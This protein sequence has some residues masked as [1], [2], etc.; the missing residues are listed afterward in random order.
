MRKEFVKIAIWGFGAMGSGM[1]RLILSKQGFEITGVCDRN[2]AY[3]GKSMYT[4]LG[5]DR[6][7]HPDVVVKADI[8]EVVP[9]RSCDLALLCTDSFTA[10]AFPKIKWLLERGVDVI[11]TAEEMAYPIAR[12]PE[13]SREMDRIAKENGVTVLGTGI[14]PG[15]MMDLLVVMLTGVMADVAS[16]RVSRINS[17]SPFGETVMEEQG[18]GL[19]VA[20]FEEKHRNGTIAGHVGFRESSRMMADA[21]GWKL[22]R[23]EQQMAPIVTKTDR[24]SSYGFAAAGDVAGVDMTAQGYV[25]GRCAIDMRHPQ[26][27]EPKLGNVETGDYIDIHGHPNVAMA[28]TPEID[29]GIGT[30][31]ICVNMIPHVINARPG[32]KT[33]LDL[34]VP[35]AIMGDVRVRIEAG[36]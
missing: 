21:L 28:I 15:V 27:I 30:I 3:V 23:F 2:P 31:A 10:K 20:S 34:P 35:R 8:A 29:G 26:Q 32:L 1:A 18:V 19:T 6:G 24:K 9:P 4:I 22:E 25:D 17:L 12:E 16:I 5:I 13:L 33:M 36:E 14:N 7:T 11:S